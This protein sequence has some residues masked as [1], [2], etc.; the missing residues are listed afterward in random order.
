MSKGDNN[1]L[2]NLATVIGG[3]IQSF[4][5]SNIVRFLPYKWKGNAKKETLEFKIKCNLKPSELNRIE[6]PR[7][8]S[9]AHN[10]WD[11]V[12]IGLYYFVNRRPP[13]EVSIN[14]SDVDPESSMGEKIPK[15][16]PKKPRGSR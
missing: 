7:A 8:K 12:G 16:R 15:T 4:P 11:A 6:I 5:E 2:L 10:V 14:T 13:R 3:I 9:L 1:D